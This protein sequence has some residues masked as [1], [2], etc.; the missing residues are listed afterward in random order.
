[1]TPSTESAMLVDFHCHLDLFPDMDAA[2]AAA[3]SA[4][5]LSLTVTTTPRAWPRNRDLASRTRNVKSGLGLHP[6]L[7][8]ERASELGLW[9]Q[10]LP[11]ARFVGEVGLDGGPHYY[12]SMP[13]QLRVFER[14]LVKC[15]N[16]GG[17]I[18]TVHSYRA[19]SKVLD[20]I[21][22]Y[23]PPERGRVVLHW[24]TGSKSE[25]QRAIGLGCYF[26]VNSEMLRSERSQEIIR[27]LPF[28]KLLT[29][30]DAPFIEVQG[31]PSRPADVQS[32]VDS[33]AALLGRTSSEVRD[34]V[35]QN[36][37]TLIS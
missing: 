17:K 7:V 30:T 22:N 34:L 19:A 28:D 18:L 1:M 6:Q 25:A 16:A 27:L 36:A 35:Y 4:G 5:V 24:F 33:L 21:E 23:L 20:L 8:A 29:E 2:I 12:Q 15:A 32:A 26:S 13:E 37:K 11:E 31:K 14:I 10:F 3:E 9:E